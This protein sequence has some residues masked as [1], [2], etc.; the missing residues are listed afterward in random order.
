MLDVSILLFIDVDGVLNVPG[1]APRDTSGIFRTG[2]RGYPSPLTKP[3]LQ[4]IAHADHIQPMWMSFWGIEA[5]SW[6]RYA[7]TKRF[8]VAYPLSQSSPKCSLE[9]FRWYI[10]KDG[11]YRDYWRGHYLEKPTRELI[12]FYLQHP[13]LVDF[14]DE[15]KLYHELED[16]TLSA[17]VAAH[18]WQGEI[19]WIEDGHPKTAEKWAELD[20]R[21][22]LVDTTKGD[23]VGLFD[24]MKPEL[25]KLLQIEF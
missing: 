10:K 22:I 1:D 16:K 17:L 14:E 15:L 2:F 20:N 24:W 6:N 13:C 5:H 12:N 21:V 3:F 7:Q 25:S 9:N 4:A 8:P 19:V 18:E 11:A 23:P